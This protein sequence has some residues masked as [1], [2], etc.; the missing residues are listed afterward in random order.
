MK[1]YWRIGREWL[2]PTPRFPEV[3]LILQEIGDAILAED[4]TRLIQE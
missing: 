1:K 4:G 3:G 2:L